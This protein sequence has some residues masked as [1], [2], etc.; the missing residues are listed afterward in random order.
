MI[1]TIISQKDRNL[2][3]QECQKW[4]ETFIKNNY[5]TNYSWG[6]TKENI[7]QKFKIDENSYILNIGAGYG[8]ELVPMVNYTKHIYG[9]DISETAISLCDKHCPI[10]INK[11]YD[12]SNIPFSDNMFDFAWS[13]FV[14]QHVGKE[15]MKQLLKE[16]NRILKPNGFMA[17]EFLGGNWIAGTNKEHY[18]G[19]ITGMYNNGYTQNELIT[20]CA[21][22]GLFV[23]EIEE[24]DLSHYE[25]G[26]TNI[27]LT[28]KKY[29]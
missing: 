6:L 10:S 26:T 16:S 14:M 20:M 25:K 27:W 7:P 13:T 18:S 8:R 29:A 5:F 1:D 9:I 15:N 3:V 4:W 21:E 22:L 28:I 19:G 17:H 24:I 12:G 2:S 23:R 11:L